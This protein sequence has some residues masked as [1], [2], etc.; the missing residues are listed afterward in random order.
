MSTNIAK[1]CDVVLHHNRLTV[2]LNYNEISILL[3]L[4]VTSDTW[5]PVVQ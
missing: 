2:L 5:Q 4:F 3:N 1:A